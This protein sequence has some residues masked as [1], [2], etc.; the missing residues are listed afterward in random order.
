MNNR[1][2]GIICLFLVAITFG[3]GYGFQAMAE[4]VI[5]PFSFLTW[6]YLIASAFFLPFMFKKDDTSFKTCL[7]IMLVL[8]L[9]LSL[10]SG[11]QQMAAG[12]IHAGK[13]GFITSLYIVMVPLIEAVLFKKR[14]SFLTVISIIICLLGLVFLCD[15]RD[16]SFGFYEFIV[17][18]SAFLY[19][20]EI[21]YIDY[22]ASRVNINKF[23]FS[24]CFGTFVFCF[25]F[26]LF[27]GS[28]LLNIKNALVP[29]LY[30]GIVAG[31]L[32]YFFQSKGQSLT[33]GT[34][35][36][37]I[38]ALESVFSMIGGFVLLNQI[39]SF[40]EIGGAA[41]MFAGVVLCIVSSDKF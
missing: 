25:A 14:I 15:I 2:K 36:S 32:G 23:T 1:T 22:K 38:M 18:C 8:G 6:R 16:F 4:N 12:K 41:V 34:V 7:E 30:M 31:A 28:E 13:I 17:L 11:F 39:P 10:A 33:P 35:A 5:A 24:L 9:V 20:L 37:L 19:A 29:V 3:F 21:I 27:E 26:S 40:S